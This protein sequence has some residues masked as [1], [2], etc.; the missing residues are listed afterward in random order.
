M[1]LEFFAFE[2]PAFLTP[3]ILPAAEI[4]PVRAAECVT[5]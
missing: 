3:P 1:K 5:P 4:D 2:N